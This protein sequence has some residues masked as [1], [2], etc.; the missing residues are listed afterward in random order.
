MPPLSYLVSRPPELKKQLPRHPP[1]LGAQT[2][3]QLRRSPSWGSVR[4][5]MVPQVVKALGSLCPDILSPPQV[6]CCPLLLLTGSG[7]TRLPMPGPGKYTPRKNSS[8]SGFL[9]DIDQQIYPPETLF[10]PWGTKQWSLFRWIM[11]LVIGK[12]VTEVTFAA[13]PNTSL[14]V[15]HDGSNGPVW[16]QRKELWTGTQECDLLCGPQ[17]PPLWQEIRWDVRV[18]KPWYKSL[19]MT[20]SK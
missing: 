20:Y 17:C 14:L 18:P 15:F 8:T 5:P 6:L 2:G 11:L 19:P 3:D 4:E 10:T 9:K 12:R 7:Q 1:R 16:P 13:A